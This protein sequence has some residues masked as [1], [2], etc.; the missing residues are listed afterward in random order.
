MNESYLVSVIVPVYKT[1]KYLNRCLESIVNQTYKNL[2]IILIDDDSPDNCPQMCDEWA[3]KD[4]RIK[5]LHIENNGVANARNQGLSNATGDYIG[6]VDS[7]DFAEPDMFEILLSNILENDSDISVCGYQMNVEADVESNIRKVSRFDALKLIAMGDYKY[8]VLWNKL[9][10]NEIIKDIRMPHF[11]CCEDLV[12]NYYAFK[13]T[14][15]IV[16]C[17]DKLYHYMQNED[18]TVHGNFGIGAFD[19]VYSKEIILN[20]QQGTELEKYAVRGLISSC[21]VVLSGVVQS[22]KFFDKYD[23]LRN[24]ILNHKK[25]IYS[26]DLYSRLDKVKTA[27]LTFSP[28]IYNKFIVRK[29]R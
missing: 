9:Y 14:N 29:N 7:D 19:A 2:E 15:K 3:Q 12:F 27:L 20:E 22:G 24:H 28:K 6:F 18:S 1:E 5:V 25:D 16:E 26:S 8:G 21:F 13:N 10:K 11:A 4:N 17:D 23:Y